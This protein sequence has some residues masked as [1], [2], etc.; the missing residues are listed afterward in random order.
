MSNPSRLSL[1]MAASASASSDASDNPTHE[2]DHSGPAPSRRERRLAAFGSAV[3]RRRTNQGFSQETLAERAGV[4]RTYVGG[5][6]RGERNVSLV[7]ILALADA[8]KLSPSALMER[9]EA[10]LDLIDR[11]EE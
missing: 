10:E 3:R 7:N 1:L 5:V 2:D 11:F 4:H 8:L 9:Y 6:E